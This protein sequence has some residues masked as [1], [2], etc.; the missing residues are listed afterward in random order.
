[1]STPNT[2]NQ[3]QQNNFDGRIAGSEYADATVVDAVLNPG[4]SITA[5]DP[6]KG[7]VI[8][9]APVMATVDLGEAGSLHIVKIDIDDPNFSERWNGQIPVETYINTLAKNSAMGVWVSKDHSTTRYT[10]V[11]ALA[12]SR[13]R[14]ADDIKGGKQGTAFYAWGDSVMRT[15]Q[16]RNPVTLPDNIPEKFLHV[17]RNRGGSITL[18][19][20]G[21][22][23]DVKVRVTATRE[24]EEVLGEKWA[25][26]IESARKPVSKRL[27]HVA[28]K[29]TNKL[30]NRSYGKR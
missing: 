6:L 16:P 5:T 8:G 29:L 9:G 1:M 23:A 4:E 10:D 26:E 13:S 24:H 21:E 17:E 25:N 3:D 28:G 2:I 30:V 11:I 12:G 7:N 18:S 14:A 15:D 27:A 20:L 19:A 22:A